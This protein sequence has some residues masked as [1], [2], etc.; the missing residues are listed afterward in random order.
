ML[1]T[2]IQQA[3][4]YWRRVPIKYL[5]GLATRYSFN[6]YNAVDPLLRLEVDHG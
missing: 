4:T 1:D 3:P 5:M 6:N 2:L